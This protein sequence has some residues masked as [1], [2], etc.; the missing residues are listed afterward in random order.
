M[1][2]LCSRQIVIGNYAQIIFT[3]LIN[4][5]VCN[6]SSSSLQSCN[7]VKITKEHHLSTYVTP[8]IA[9]YKIEISVKMISRSSPKDYLL[10]FFLKFT[11]SNIFE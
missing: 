10:K 4:K 9:D 5:R 6:F 7:V 8:S 2:L 11:F 3:E 1:E